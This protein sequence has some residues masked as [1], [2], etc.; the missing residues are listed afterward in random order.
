MYSG[1]LEI[2]RDLLSRTEDTRNCF[3]FGSDSHF[4]FSCVNHYYAKTEES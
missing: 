1:A 4:L 2:S 3:G